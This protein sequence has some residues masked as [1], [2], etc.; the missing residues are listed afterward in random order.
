MPPYQI[1]VAYGGHCYWHT[2]FVTSQC[3]VIFTLANQRFGEVCWHNMHIQG[4]RSSCRA[5]G[6]VKQLRE[7]ETYKNK[8]IVTK[9]VC[10]CSSTTL[11]SKI[12]KKFIEN[13]SEFSECLNSCNKFV[14]N[15]SWYAM[16]VPVILLWKAVVLEVGEQAHPQKFWFAKNLS[17]ITENPGINGAQR[18]LTSKY[19]TQGLKKNTWRPIFG[20]PTEKCFSWSLWEKIC[21]QNYTK[22]FSGK[23]GEIRAKILRTPKNSP[24]LTSTMKRHIGLHCLLLKGQRG[25]CFCHA[26]ILRHPCAYYSTLS[27]LVVVGYSVSLKWT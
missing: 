4:R 19:D 7:M 1:P 20:G 2:L 27:L 26:S 25:K 16:K 3:D 11:T 14:S 15:Q 8:K 24:A 10:F 6:A 17:K 23:F 21:R 12:I 22:N 5:G 9:Y 13:H 18:C